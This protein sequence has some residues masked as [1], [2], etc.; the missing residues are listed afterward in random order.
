MFITFIRETHL[1]YAKLK[2]NLK[3]AVKGK[4]GAKKQTNK[5]QLQTAKL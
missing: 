1:T 5:K 4:I 2:P 3:V